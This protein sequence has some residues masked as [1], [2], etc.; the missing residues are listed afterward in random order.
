MQLCKHDE[1]QSLVDGMTF[2]LN[3][4]KNPAYTYREGEGKKAIESY[5]KFGITNSQDKETESSDADVFNISG[6]NDASFS[7]STSLYTSS[8]KSKLLVSIG[9]GVSMIKVD[10]SGEFKRVSGT[11]IGGGTLV[12]LVNMMTGIRDFNKIIEMGQSG[13]HSGVDYLVKDIYGDKSRFKE[14][15][16]DWLASSFARVGNDSET[17]P[18]A[19]GDKYK[20]EDIIASVMFMISYNVAQIATLVSQMHDI[21]DIIFVGNYVKAND[22]GKEKIS[23]G[24]DLNSGY[25]KRP[26]FLTFDGYLGAIGAFLQEFNNQK[27]CDDS[28]N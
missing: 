8:Q 16:M 28:C 5:G 11:A 12:G 27:Q 25:T 22:I 20:K 21:D 19:L 10:P 24:V 2:V 15:Q 26:L 6:I 3:F 14:L 4:A 13:D 17:E 18:S 23:F 9:S 7:D 1:M